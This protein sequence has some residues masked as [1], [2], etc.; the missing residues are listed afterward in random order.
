MTVDKNKTLATPPLALLSRNPLKWFRF[1]GPGAIVASVSIGT[2]EILFPSRGGSIFGYQ[3]L[4]IFLVISLMKWGLAYCSIR[5][6]ILSGAHP[7][8]RW[9]SIPGPRGWFPLLMILL[10]VPFFPIWLSFIAGI[11]G[12]ACTWIFG[13]GNLYIWGII[14]LSMALILLILGSYKILEYFQTMILSLMVASIIVSVIYTQPDWVAVLKGFFYPQSL[15]YPDW[16]LEKL[17]YLETRSIWVEILVY[18]SV[19]GG[20]SFD[21]LSWVSFARDKKWGWSHLGL[22][23]QDQLHQIAQKPN[24]SARLWLKAAFID[25]ATSFIMIVIISASFCILGRVILQPQH[26][27]PDGIDLLNYQASFLTN[28]S[29]WLLPLYMASILLAFFGSLYGSPEMQFR[30]VYEYLNTLPNW[31]EKISVPKLRQITIVYGLVGGMA[32]LWAS[33]SYPGVQLIDIV[34]PTGILTGV[35]ACGFYCL[36]N[37]WTDR[38]FLPAKLRMSGWLIALNVVAG[39]LFLLA[40]TKALWDYFVY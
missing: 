1:F 19:I 10:C 31:R 13:I 8:E 11:F 38:R 2:G 5:H 30:V 7:F 18:V 26:L 3:L 34:T 21:Y 33:S 29:T 22:A 9:S 12:N 20:P 14:G 40:G 27:I 6:M 15:A 37:P 39:V 4:W 36:A 28:L 35:L 17:P 32:I 23:S 24:H 25:S 16:A